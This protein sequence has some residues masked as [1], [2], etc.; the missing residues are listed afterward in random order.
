MSAGT[1]HARRPRKRRALE[2][3]SR[4]PVAQCCIAARVWPRLP[5]VGESVE[6]PNGT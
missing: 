5:A 6:M 4:R 2:A 3:P 1:A